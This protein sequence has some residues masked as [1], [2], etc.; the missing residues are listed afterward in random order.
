MARRRDH[1]PS[2]ARY[3]AGMHNRTVDRFKRW[4]WQPPRP[5]G[6]IQRDRVVSN[7]E[8]FYDLVYVAVI[9]QAAI[10]LAEDVSVAARARVRGRVRHDLARLAQRVAV[11]RDPRAPGRA[12]PE[13]RVRPDGDPRPAR[14]VRGRR[15]GRARRRVRGHLRG[16]ARRH[17]LAVAVRPRAGPAGVHRDHPRLRAGDGGFGR[18]RARERV[19]ARRR[20]ACRLGSAHGRLGGRLPPPGPPTGRSRSR[21]RRRSR[22]SSG[23]G[24]SRSSSSARS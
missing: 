20:P 7:L 13:R 24:C 6:A 12:D 21:S 14:G 17:D 2:G 5:H 9:G 1:A 3:A 15:D 4:F 19:P 11:P 8:L 16:A 10:L 23:S 22:W 18:G